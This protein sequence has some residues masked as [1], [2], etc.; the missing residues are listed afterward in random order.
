[1]GMVS[2]DKRVN[3]EEQDIEGETEVYKACKERAT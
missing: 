2:S 1:M 3:Q